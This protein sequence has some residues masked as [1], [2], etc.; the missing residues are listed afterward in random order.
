MDEPRI[1]QHLHP[2]FHKLSKRPGPSF[3]STSSASLGMLVKQWLREYLSGDYASSRTR[4]RIHQF[5]YRGLTTWRVF[6]IMA[7][8]PT[9]LQISLILFLVGLIDFLRLVHTGVAAVI[10]VTVG[11]W[12]FVYVSTTFLP[13][14]VPDCPYKSP[15]ARL[16]YNLVRVLKGEQPWRIR[17]LSPHLSWRRFD[18]HAVSNQVLEVESLATADA[19][20]VDDDALQT[21]I[22]PCFKDLD[23]LSTIECLNKTCSDRLQVSRLESIKSSVNRLSERAIHTISHI[24]MDTLDSAMKP[25][26]SSQPIADDATWIQEAFEFVRAAMDATPEESVLPSMMG[27]GKRFSKLLL[28]CLEGTDRTLISEALHALSSH[29]AV[30]S[31]L[32]DFLT[33][34]SCE[35]F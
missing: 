15:Q 35:Y 30:C 11:I 27:M 31:E 26:S 2:S 32:D 18:T 23:G 17:S 12:L 22:G 1:L 8:L 5:R 6:E 25:T 33:L 3:K 29:P 4:A 19:T 20:F 14:L 9:L 24:I 7:F 16:V 34:P 13:T 28:R 10:S 21:I